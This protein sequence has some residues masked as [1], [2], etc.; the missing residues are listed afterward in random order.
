[1]WQV[2][3]SL[4]EELTKDADNFQKWAIGA[5][6]NAESLANTN[7]TFRSE[8]SFDATTLITGVPMLREDGSRPHASADRLAQLWPG[9][10]L[11]WR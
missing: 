5:L 2:E 8:R 10:V 6:N 3:A 4:W 11:A 1:V 9:S 7:A